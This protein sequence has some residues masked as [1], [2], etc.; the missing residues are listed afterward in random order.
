MKKKQVVTKKDKKDWINFAKNIKNV[1]PKDV[2]KP[3]E[4]FNPNIVKKLDLHGYSLE[5]ANQKVKFFLIKSFDEGYKKVLIVTGKGKHSKAYDDPYRSSKLSIM[6]YS[7][8]D[9]IKG[10]KNLISKIKKISEANIEDG[11]EGALYIFLKNK[12]R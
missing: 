7:I 1:A 12:L 10:D 8:P 2:D 11:G 4:N 9:Y 5:T 3:I 6:K